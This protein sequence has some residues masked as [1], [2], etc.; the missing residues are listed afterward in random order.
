MAFTSWFGRIGA[1]ILA[2][3]IPTYRAVDH[4]ETVISG[5]RRL[6]TYNCKT[7]I[8]FL[9]REASKRNIFISFLPLS[10]LEC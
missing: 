8:A 2:F 5:R 1:F 3:G 10:L 4:E 9:Q 7:S 6:D